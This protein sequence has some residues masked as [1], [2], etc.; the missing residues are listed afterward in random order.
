MHHPEKD[1]LLEEGEPVT[2]QGMKKYSG[3]LDHQG[4]LGLPCG[5]LEEGSGASRP[6]HQAGEEEVHSQQ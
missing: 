6:G 1:S 4:A 2:R 5:L 3:Y